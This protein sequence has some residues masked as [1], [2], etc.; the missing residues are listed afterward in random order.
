MKFLTRYTASQA[1]LARITALGPLVGA[2]ALLACEEPLKPAQRIDSPRVLG[3]RVAT[4][5]G[6]AS[7]TPGAEAE[8]EVLLA[9]P[10]GALDA[11]LAYRF[12]EAGSSDRGVP[13]CAGQ[14]LAEGTV[15]AGAGAI[16]LELPTSLG[17]GVRLTLLGAACTRGEP[18]LALDPLDWSCSSG[19]PPLGLSFDARTG[20]KDPAN[21]NPGLGELA[22][23]VGAEVVALEAALAAPSC[24]PGVRRVAA[25]ATERV[26]CA[27][28][29]LAREPGEALQASHFATGGDFERH[30]SF[31]AAEQPAVATLTWRAPRVAGAVKQYLV[32]RD[33]RG[34]VSWA[35]WSVCIY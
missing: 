7:L 32:L 29:E 9:G 25:G 26:E 8:A 33:D 19:E 4:A 27:L 3:V 34:G 12:C 1:R 30:F 2:V 24:A 23:S 31:I 10:E 22:V 20:D 35:T 11:R 28:G 6:E 21:L 5:Q 17:E 18:L 16:A 13:Y 14:A 15:D